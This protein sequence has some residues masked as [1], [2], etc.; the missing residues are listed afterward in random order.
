[1]TRLS[2]RLSF[3]FARRRHVAKQRLVNEIPQSQHPFP[4]GA[5]VG[6][7]SGLIDDAGSTGA[8]KIDHQGQRENAV[9]AAERPDCV[10]KDERRVADIY[11][12]KL[13]SLSGNG[14]SGF[15]GQNLSSQVLEAGKVGGNP[16]MQGPMHVG[17][18]PAFLPQPDEVAA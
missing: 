14:N 11:G 10:E 7:N 16:S 18:N 13:G 2:V 3:G 5:K 6:R 12:S 1:M 15:V 9:V 17:L 4:V 8:R